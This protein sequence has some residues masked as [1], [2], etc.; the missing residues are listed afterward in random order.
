MPCFDFTDGIITFKENGKTCCLGYLLTLKGKVFD[1]SMGE[2][3][4]TEE[5]ADKHNKVFDSM[6]VK[7]L[8][9]CAIGQGHTFYYKPSTKQ[10][11]TWLGTVIGRSSVNAK[12]VTV[13]YNG[14]TFQGNLRKSDDS[15]FLKRTQ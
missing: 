13:S 8:D 14:K 3:D 11:I 5:Q 6:I 4:V 1:A 12:Q 10:V 7:G 2:V 15:I 9:T